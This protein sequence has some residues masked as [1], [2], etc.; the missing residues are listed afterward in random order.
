MPILIPICLFFFVAALTTAPA[1]TSL[2]NR[3]PRQHQPNRPAWICVSLAMVHHFQ[4]QTRTA[5]TAAVAAE[6]IL[7]TK[8]VTFLKSH[9][10]VNANAKVSLR[11]K[12]TPWTPIIPPKG[13]TRAKKPVRPPPKINP[14]AQSHWT[15]RSQVVRAPTNTPT[16]AM[17]PTHTNNT[18]SITIPI[19]C[20]HHQR[21]SLP[22]HHRPAP[23]SAPPPPPTHPS[24]PRTLIWPVPTR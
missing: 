17:A 2:V 22:V 21:P 14:P 16:A 19:T 15:N 10:P 5:V 9:R 13:Q 8:C 18:N 6:I 1:T 7:A 12:R 11:T 4:I 20:I 23:T 24:R 3:Q